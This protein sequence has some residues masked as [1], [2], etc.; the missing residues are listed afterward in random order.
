MAPDQE[1]GGFREPSALNDT[2]RSTINQVSPVEESHELDPVVTLKTWIVS[3]VSRPGFA[4]MHTILTFPFLSSI[5]SFLRLWSFFL[6]GSGVV[7][8]WQLCFCRAGK[9]V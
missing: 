1:K 4:G 3:C 7:C 8:H 5:D 2:S 6:P 9:C